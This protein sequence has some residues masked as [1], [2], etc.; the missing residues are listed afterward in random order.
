MQ[1]FANLNG[2]ID[3]VRAKTS[4]T[5]F[6]DDASL[7][8]CNLLEKLIKIKHYCECQVQKSEARHCI[9]EQLNYDCPELLLNRLAAC[10]DAPASL[11]ASIL[12]C[13]DAPSSAPGSILT[14]F[15]S[16]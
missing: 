15:A 16:Y 12:T 9:V 13:N 2:K 11:P 14:G 8:F 7:H 3:M 4:Q 6:E 10:G 5:C 1:F